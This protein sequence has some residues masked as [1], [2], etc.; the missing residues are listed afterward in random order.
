M[1]WHPEFDA[2]GSAAIPLVATTTM[3]SPTTAKTTGWRIAPH[4][5][6]SLGNRQGR[7]RGQDPTAGKTSA[8]DGARGEPRHDLAVEEDE[9]DQR[10]DRDQQDVREQQV[11]LRVVLRLEV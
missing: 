7:W 5:E 11:V 9:H 3:S 1:S 8:L 6:G 10:R 2:Q 4:I